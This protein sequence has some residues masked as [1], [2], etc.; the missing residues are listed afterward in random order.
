V[1]RFIHRTG[2]P[3]AAI[4]AAA[5][6]VPRNPDLTISGVTATRPG[7]SPGAALIVLAL[8]CLCST[9]AVAQWNARATASLGRGYGN[10]ALSQSILSG[11]RRLGAG[12]STRSSAARPAALTPAQIDAALTYTADPRQSDRIRAAMIDTVSGQNAATRAE[13]EKAFADDAVLKE[14]ERFVSGRG[15]SSHNVADDMAELLLVCWEIYTGGT[16]SKAQIEGTHQQVRGVFLGNPTLRAMTN[17]RRQDMAER[18]AYQV[19]IA[20]MARQ[21]ALRS[22]D[23]AQLAQIQQSTA[24]MLRAQVGIDISRQRLTENGF[25]SKS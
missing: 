20:F 7:R 5:L 24:A 11:T 15:Y 21:E 25:R 12:A 19:V 9:A 10:I 14:F 23:Q 22:G 18:A 1:R 4:R 3:I 2:S 13:M 6:A 17:A 16:A 8:G